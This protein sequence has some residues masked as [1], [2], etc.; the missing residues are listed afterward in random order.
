MEPADSL[1]Y[2]PDYLHPEYHSVLKNPELVRQMHERGIGVNPYT[3]DTAEEMKLLIE[4]GCDGI[5]TNR[6]D[7]A[8][9]MADFK[10]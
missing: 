5:I 7:I 4:A 9:A 1:G 10:Q 8:Q 3:C 2:K 6:P